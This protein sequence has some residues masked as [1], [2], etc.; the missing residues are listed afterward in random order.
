MNQQIAYQISLNQLRNALT[1]HGYLA[2]MTEELNY[3]RVFARDGIITGLAGLVSGETDLIKGLSTT[4]SSLHS[5]CGPIGQIPS[6]IQFDRNGNVTEVSYGKNSG[7]VDVNLWFIIGLCEYTLITGDT[8]LAEAM[9]ETVDRCLYL[10]SVWEYNSRGLIYV[11]DG[12]DWADEYILHGYSLHV[13]LLRIWALRLYSQVWKDKSVTTQADGF[14]ELIGLNYW[15][16]RSVD[17]GNYYHPQAVRKYWKTEDEPQFFLAGITP[18]GY[19]LHFDAFSNALAIL[20]DVPTTDQREKI[21]QFG[22]ELI[23]GSVL[24]LI[25]AFWPP[26]KPEEKDWESLLANVLY[27]FR[28]QP[29]KYH[30]GGT[31]PMVNGWW[32]MALEKSGVRASE[33]IALAVNEFNKKDQETEWGFHEY[34]D[35]KTGNP[36]GVRYCTW[37]AAGAILL[38]RAIAGKYL[39]W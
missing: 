17:L 25:P 11:P 8:A 37:S 4:L 22:T 15:P 33:N 19:D 30:N 14:T 10:T 23:Q 36:E 1:K 26:I 9:K 31:W 7:R 12:G 32:G 18:G 35:T 39:V 38:D 34:G 16:E 21:V 28:N 2:S 29:Y 27:S 24:K 6:N 13:Q 3:K 20:L 5:N